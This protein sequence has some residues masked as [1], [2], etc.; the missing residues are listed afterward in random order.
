MVDRPPSQKGLERISLRVPSTSWWSRYESALVDSGLTE[1]AR[2]V[3]EYDSTY[4]V[5]HGIFGSGHPDDG[6][7]PASR[8]RQGL[9]MGA[10]Q[11]GKTASMLGVIAL[12]LDRKIDLIIVLAGTRLALWEQTYRRLSGQLRLADML[13]SAQPPLLVP[14]AGSLDNESSEPPSGRLYEVARQRYRRL[15]ANGQP[16]IAVVMKHPS[17]L[18]AMTRAIKKFFIPAIEEDGRSAHMLVIDDEADDGSILDADRERFLDPF[19]GHNK[20]I[21]P[22]IVDLWADRNSRQAT[23]SPLLYSTYIAY[24]ATPQANFL[25]SSQNPL[26]PTDFV[27]AL[28]TPY[29]TGRLTPRSETFLEPGGHCAYY[30]GG[31][32]FYR[33]LA[34][35][36]I[37]P[38]AIGPTHLDIA[39]A[40]RAYLVAGAIKLYTDPHRI[41]PADVA[42]TTWP[43]REDARKNTPRPHSMLVHTSADIHNHFT[44]AQSLAH[45]A[46]AAEPERPPGHETDDLKSIPVDLV[47]Q[48][49][50]R[51]EEEWLKWVDTYRHNAE[52]ISQEFGLPIQIDCPDRSAWPT[53][54]QLIL[55]QIVPYMRISVVNSGERADRHPNFEPLETNDGWAARNPLF[56]IFVSG[57]VMSRGLTL[58][59][60]TTTVFTRP[61]TVQVAD[62]RMQ[63]QRWFGYRGRDIHLTQVFLDHQQLDDFKAFHDYDDNLR[64]QI[65]REMDERESSGRPAPTPTVLQ[66]HD[67]L[68]TAKI[69]NVT[70]NPL[71]CGAYP[72]VSIINDGNTHDPNID[73][74]AKLF[75]SPAPITLTVAN[76]VRGLILNEPLS[77]LET[78]DILDSLRY[79][80]YQ[81]ASDGWNADRWA[82]AHKTIFEPDERPSPP[83]FQPPPQPPGTDTQ[84]FRQ[85]CPYNIAAYLRLWDACTTRLASGL[86]D[87][88]DQD[89]L[90]NMVDLEK[91]H[92]RKPRFY[93]GIRFG[94]GDLLTEGPL[95]AL[96]VR[97]MSR[98]TADGKLEATWGT[99]NQ[100]P[101]SHG[102]YYGDQWFDYHHHGHPNRFDPVNP[103][104][105][106]EGA[107]GLVLF[108][109][110]QTEHNPVVAVG[111]GIPIGGPDQFASRHRATNG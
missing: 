109:I 95:G 43:T 50:N 40:V 9:V 55:D 53:L 44:I 22:A 110:I 41:P 32:T 92:R 49:M 91:K 98:A 62:T 111:L 66:G 36:P 64:K 76:R 51:S 74:V 6:N 46:F 4:I 79:D 12:A 35:L 102:K 63:M 69:Q 47:E 99:R 38:P 3:I 94:Q 90:W 75:T 34:S 101:Q 85:D 96:N 81:P 100:S 73:V 80:R 30:T 16:V 58:E 77:M 1:T 23:R 25:Q 15:H 13:P 33:R 65:L 93:I 71:C 106:P 31:E 72:F 52:A 48:A 14:A 20:Q 37:C 56:T 82:A 88:A 83:F 87:S 11:S 89:R 29:D 70:A 84:E 8:S 21:P 7:W 26:A 67:R 68:A 42:N 61:G 24:T 103:K 107:P 39:R 17:H 2:K 59:G 105:R 86:V 108:H 19:G 18:Q 54:R 45:W 57:N 27:V 28:R 10:V 5:E 60:L 97:L 104:W 78:A